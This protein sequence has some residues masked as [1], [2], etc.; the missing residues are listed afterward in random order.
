MQLLK[1]ERFIKEYTNFKERIDKIDNET[2]KKDLAGLLS[3]L[4]SEVQTI[5]RQ[6]HDLFLGGKSVLR[7]DE[8]H[9]NISVL[10][11]KISQKLIDFEKSKS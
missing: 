6:H 8:N 10:R 2:I 4:H 5:D 3:K 1:N 9:N 7:I 11:K